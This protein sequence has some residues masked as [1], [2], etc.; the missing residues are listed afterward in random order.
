LFFAIAAAW[1]L[2]RLLAIAALYGG[3]LFAVVSNCCTD[4]GVLAVELVRLD[5]EE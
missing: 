3:R 2:A 4:G 5:E 1:L